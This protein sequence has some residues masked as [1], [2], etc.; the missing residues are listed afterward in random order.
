MPTYIAYLLYRYNEE[1][2]SVMSHVTTFEA[3]L[4]T[5]AIIAAY[6]GLQVTVSPHIDHVTKIAPDHIQEGSSEHHSNSEL[7]ASW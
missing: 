4:S 6:A 3:S 7:V 5:P 2:A 1:A